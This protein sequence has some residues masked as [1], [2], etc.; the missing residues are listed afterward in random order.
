MKTNVDK[1]MRA[2]FTAKE[3]IILQGQ[4]SKLAAKH[5]CTQTYVNLI[6]RG[7]REIST[8]LSKKIYQ[9]LK[10]LIELLSPQSEE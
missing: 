4:S 5:N 8:D 1:K 6:I 9:D 10:S 7:E 3:K 2:A